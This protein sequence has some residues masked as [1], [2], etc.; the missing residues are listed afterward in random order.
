MF[1]IIDAEVK[2]IIAQADD[3]A[4]YESQTITRLVS[5]LHANLRIDCLCLLCSSIKGRYSYK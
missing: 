5:K 2:E 3:E 1:M 4:G